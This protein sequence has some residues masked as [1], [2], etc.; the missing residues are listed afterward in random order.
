LGG[1]LKARQKNEAA[2]TAA[3]LASMLEN[4]P[5]GRSPSLPRMAQKTNNRVLNRSDFAD[6]HPFVLT[7]NET[8]YRFS[9]LDT[10]LASYVYWSTLNQRRPK[11]LI[12]LYEERLG[13]RKPIKETNN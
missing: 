6:R 11:R 13:Y 8:V 3:T 2:A 10:A 9:N 5:S 1:L 12:S 7:V 4:H